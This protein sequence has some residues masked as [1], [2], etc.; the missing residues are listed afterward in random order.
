MLEQRNGRIQGSSLSAITA[1]QKLGGSVTA[2]VAGSGVTAG[3]AAE[4][5]KIKGLDKVLAVE[6]DAYEKVGCI[7]GFVEGSEMI[8]V[9]ADSVLIGL[10]M[11]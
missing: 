9:C 11:M 7:L 2:F 3:A 8:L 6:N 5:A 1:A 4:A 10:N